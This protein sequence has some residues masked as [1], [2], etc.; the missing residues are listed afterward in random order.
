MH[1]TGITITKPFSRLLIC[2]IK[3]MIAIHLRIPS[4]LLDMILAICI[5]NKTKQKKPRK[6]PRSC[7]GPREQKN[8]KSSSYWVK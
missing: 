3:G 7:R 5:K 8:Y 1:P 4:S 6:K 2:Q